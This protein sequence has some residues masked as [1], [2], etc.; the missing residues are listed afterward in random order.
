[1]SFNSIHFIIFSYCNHNIFHYSK[2]I[3]YLWLLISSYYFYISWNPK[4]AILIAFSTLTTYIAGLLIDISDKI[5]NK[6]KSIF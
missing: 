5:S 1:M 4:Y 2:K 6:K 3:K